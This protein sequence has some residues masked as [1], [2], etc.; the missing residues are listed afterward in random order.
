M[1]KIPLPIPI[2]S[3]QSESLPFSA[4][5]CINWIPTIPQAEALNNRALMMR[6]GVKQFAT[7]SFG[8]CRGAWVMAG[9]PYFVNGTT[10]ISIS[11]AGIVTNH[12]E[13]I[14]TSRVSMDD[15]GSKLVIVVPGSNSY[16]FDVAIPALAQ[17]TDTD[18]KPASSVAFKDGFYI[19]S[20]SDGKTFFHSAINDPFSYDALEFGSAE[21][22]SDLIVSVHV[23]HNEL[24]VPGELTIELF[25]NVGG[26]GF[27]FQRIPGANITRGSASKYGTVDFDGDYA[28]IGG[29]VNELASIWRV[30]GSA[31]TQKISTDAIDA[32]LQKFTKE[33]LSEA[34]SMTYSQ[35]GQMFAIFTFNSER[36]PGKTFVY[37]GSASALAG[38]HVWFELQSGV[39]DAP[40][41]VNAIV[42]AYG[43]IL[44]GD[45]VDG[46]IGYL[47]KN[48]YDEYGEPIFQQV[49]TAPFSNGGNAI[50]AGDF[51]ATF[52]SGVGLTVGQG[53]NPIVRM[54][55]SDD[56]ARTWSSEFSRNI[57][58]IGEYGHRAIWRRQGRF[59]DQ[60]VI[61]LTKTDPVKGNLIRL[62]ATPE[63][64]SN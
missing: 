19:F 31:S 56:G 35:N 21:V 58:K 13:I 8:A 41:R 30:I 2:G 50:F 12:G 48:T 28:F 57:G 7:S 60:R 24:S 54:D 14:G 20:A 23:N 5:R 63:F 11:S 36:I 43:K 4:Q 42:K 18:F 38:A 59:P 44:C 33:E 6:P 17:I 39:V 25:Q 26:T 40:W 27:V 1:P 61:R 53:S 10:L 49:A 22:S 55:F 47:D 51:E 32:E 9:V 37:N 45:S 46:R 62:T 15:N 34:F 52:E 16:V 29:G 3:Y 64:G